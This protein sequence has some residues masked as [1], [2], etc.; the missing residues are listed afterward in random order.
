MPS[1]PLILV[2]ARP[3]PAGAAGR[4]PVVAAGQRYL[5]ALWRAGAQEMVVSPRDLAPDEVSALLERVDGLLLLGGPDVTP[6]LYGQAARPEV[7]GTDPVSDG[8]EIALVRAAAAAGLPT[9]GICR[10]LQVM[11]VALGGTLHQHISDQL[12]IA[13]RSPQGFPTPPPTSTAPM[14]EVDVREGSLLAEALGATTVSGSHS[15]HQAVDRQG[16]GLR[17]CAG[18]ADG[19]IEGLELDT[20]WMIGVQWHPEDTAASDPA[21]Q[22]LF[23][24][25]VQRAA[26]RAG[27][28]TGQS[29]SEH[30]REESRRSHRGHPHGGHPATADG[31]ARAS[32]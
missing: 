1:R 32:T 27:P 16:D 8:F 29:R 19:V 10:G 26:G 11:N 31:G 30:P 25:L 6:T 23:D 12:G 28:G 9:L 5:A 4:L 20:G 22:R 17:W 18:A 3:L 7:Y 13:P 21:Q 2:P 14:V 15:H 24:T